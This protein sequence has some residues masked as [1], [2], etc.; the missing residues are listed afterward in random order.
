MIPAHTYLIY[1]LLYAVAVAIP[2]PGILAIVARALGGGF[3]GTIPA[4]LGNTLGDLILMSLSTF[5]LA[6]VAHQ[7]GSLFLVVKLAGAAY[8]I[9]LGYRYWTAPVSN[10]SGAD[11]VSPKAHQGFLAQ[12]MLTL[13]NPKGL[14]F[15][16]ALMPGVIDLNRLNA[17]G[18][19]QL[20]T[21]TLILIPT[22]ELA[23]AALASQVRVF[24]AGVTARR[25]L[26]K[27][28]AAIMISAGVG[29]AVT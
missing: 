28:A 4:V 24:L 12:L 5:G 8:L 16:L 21:V 10:V 6:V 11:L 25:R 13:G 1:F 26:N 19:A 23:Y 7:L 20:C 22:I 3:R 18:Y 29:V 2:G 15:F 9:W 17:A 14:V 27:G